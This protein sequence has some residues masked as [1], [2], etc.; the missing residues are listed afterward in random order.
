MNYFSNFF[1]ASAS[2]VSFKFLLPLLGLLVLAPPSFAKTPA[3]ADHAPAVEDDPRIALAAKAAAAFIADPS[4]ERATEHYEIWLAGQSYASVVQAYKLFE[5]ISLREPELADCAR[6]K[7]SITAEITA[8]PFAL[9]PGV[10]A[11]KCAE[12]AGESALAAQLE[13]RIHVRLSMLLADG[14]G[15]L[16]ITSAKLMSWWDIS[17]FADISGLQWRSTRYSGGLSVSELSAYTIFDIESATAEVTKSAATQVS[18]KQDRAGQHIQTS[19]YF[20]FFSEKFRAGLSAL[21]YETPWQRMASIQEFM[22]ELAHAEDVGAKIYLQEY[23]ISTEED[24]SAAMIALREM[25]KQPES[26]LQTAIALVQIAAA[27]EKIKLVES[28]LEPLFEAAEAYDAQAIMALAMERTFGLVGP[29]DLNEAEQLLRTAL[30]SNS[31]AN[32]VALILLTSVRRHLPPPAF[33]LRALQTQVDQK[34][35]TALVTAYIFAKGYITPPEGGAWLSELKDEQEM[36]PSLK[37]ATRAAV[38]TSLV[39]IDPSA[40]NAKKMACEAAAF[41]VSQA[42]FRCAEYL[43]ESEQR[44]RYFVETAGEGDARAKGSEGKRIGVISEQL[45]EYFEYFDT[46]TDLNRAAQWALSG[47]AFDN[48]A[49]YKSLARLAMR[50]AKLTDFDWNLARRLYAAQTE[51]TRTEQ[52]T[53]ELAFA[54]NDARPKLFAELKAK[55]RAGN[56][57]ACAVLANALDFKA[58]DSKALGSRIAM[59]KRCVRAKDHLKTTLCGQYLGMSYVYGDNVKK[60]AAR[61]L[62]YLEQLEQPSIAVIN[63]IAWIRCTAP[64]PPL[65]APTKVTQYWPQLISAKT[66]GF[67]DTLAACYAS[68]GMFERASD[69]LEKIISNLT[70]GQIATHA[71]TTD[72]DRARTLKQTL[73]QHLKAFQARKR[74]VEADMN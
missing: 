10:L 33:A 44:L 67:Q 37:G 23:A 62:A 12:L 17:A 4:L 25:L 41:G 14:R 73:Q 16:Q 47:V 11:L 7:E 32:D 65:Y 13:A 8:N 59:L 72:G 6:E 50:G 30:K 53:F 36:F 66:P 27:N 21:D 71:K 52:T 69:M 40:P 9:A 34:L 54:G 2:C 26:A 29:A 42:K 70:D 38:F 20:D 5:R 3:S 49:S 18:S 31:G 74:W 51:A 58:P 60:D 22:Q 68:S 43:E 35:P 48:V 39:A 64:A 45:A 56:A 24:E 63:T 19:Y 57:P 1:P 46:P 15:Q 28:D 61:G 55:C